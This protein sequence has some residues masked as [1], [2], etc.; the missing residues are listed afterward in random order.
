MPAAHLNRVDLEAYFDRIEYHGSREPSVQTLTDLHLAH[1]T[2]VP[3][4]NLDVI[5]KLP[6]RLDM[7]SLQTK[8]VHYRRGGYCFEQNLLFAGVLGQLGFAVDLLQARV[9]FGTQRVIPRTHLTLAVDIE[10]QR[11]L[12][13]LGFGSCG[14]LLPILLVPGDYQQFAWHYKLARESD[15][16]V[17]QAPVGGVWQDLYV[18][19]LEPQLAVDFEPP[20]HYVSTHPDSR[21]VQ[22]LTVQRVAPEKRLVLRNTELMTTTPAGESRQKI[23]SNAE[24]IHVLSDQFGL[25]LAADAL[26]LPNLPGGHTPPA[27]TS[28]SE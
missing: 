16:F 24:L 10:N 6:I 14:L 11:W 28:R 23:A 8:I 4:E 12:A 1:A 18:F 22:T 5:L 21:F 13:D 27:A 17:L 7:E 20:N 19:D 3:F 25:R 26:L 9:R 15:R 2:H